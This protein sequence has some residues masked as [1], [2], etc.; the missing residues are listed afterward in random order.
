MQNKMKWKIINN[1]NDKKCTEMNF[2]FSFLFAKFT[3]DNAWLRLIAQQ[4]Q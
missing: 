3:A 2:F 4:I 1:N